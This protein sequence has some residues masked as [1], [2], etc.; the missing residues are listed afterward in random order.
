MG[1][2]FPY[3]FVQEFGERSETGVAKGVGELDEDVDELVEL[4]LG[5][6]FVQS[7]SV[8]IIKLF[9][10]GQFTFT[11]EGVEEVGNLFKFSGFGIVDGIEV[12]EGGQHVEEDEDL[13]FGEDA[14]VLALGA[15]L[16]GG[17][18]VDLGGGGGVVV[19]LVGGI[20]LFLLIDLHVDGGWGCG[21]VEKGRVFDPAHSLQKCCGE[22]FVRVGK[23]VI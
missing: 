22:I 18:D 15:G 6:P 9:K 12:F 14:L 7:F 8:V 20:M 11:S 5:M 16:D 17:L 1:F 4:A 23:E 21:F 2:Q 3:L 19:V 10:D 13:L